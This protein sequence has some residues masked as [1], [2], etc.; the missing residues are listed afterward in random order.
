M[1]MTLDPVPS[2]QSRREELSLI[3]S[4]FWF[5]RYA[6][7]HKLVLVVLY[8]TAC[9]SDA[10]VDLALHWDVLLIS[11]YLSWH[12]YEVLVRPPP[13][14]QLPFYPFYAR[15]IAPTPSGALLL[16][17]WLMIGWYSVRREWRKLAWEFLAIAFFMFAW[18][19]MFY[20]R[21]YRFI[22]IDW[23]FFG[24]M[25]V[26]SFMTLLFFTGFPF[27]CLRNYDKGLAQWVYVERV[28]GNDN[29]EPDL[30][31]AEVIEKE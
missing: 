20:S 12:L 28:F 31:P 27:V 9:A 29:F 11:I 6:V 17:P 4:Q 21:V 7:S 13:R 14:S 26:S 19:M 3:G 2:G 25:T 10:I 18:S 15:L 16:I 23:P 30:F 8:E 22:F 1:S 5:A 24:C